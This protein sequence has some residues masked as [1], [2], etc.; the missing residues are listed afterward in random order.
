MMSE[1]AVVSESTLGFISTIAIVA[2]G[3]RALIYKGMHR[4]DLQQGDKLTLW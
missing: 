1:E 2:S 3:Y 4:Y